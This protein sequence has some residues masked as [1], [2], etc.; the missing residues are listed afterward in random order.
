MNQ[1]NI[2]NGTQ[3][4]CK[5]CGAMFEIT[6]CHST[7]R[8]PY[9]DA[10]YAT[11]TPETESDAV[12][13]ERIRAQAA[14]DLENARRK[15]EAEAKKAAKNEATIEKF[16]KGLWSKLLVLCIAVCGFMTY[17]SFSGKF[18]PH[19][20]IFLAQTLLLLLAWLMGMGVFK[21][22][23]RP[24]RI[25]ITLMAV[26]LIFPY[27]ELPSKSE[28]SRKYLRDKIVWNNI[29]MHEIIPEPDKLAGDVTR[30]TSKELKLSLVN[31]ST[32]EYSAYRQAC[33]DA[34]FTIDSSEKSY[35]NAYAAYNE[36]GYY[37]D[38]DYWSSSE[39][40]RI[41]LNAPMETEQLDWT[42][43]VLGN[44]LPAPDSS[45]GNIEQNS[46]SS[47]SAYISNVTEED[48][49]TYT[50]RCKDAGFTLDAEESNTSFFAMNAA[51]Y[52]L[53]TS[54]EGFNR[55]HIS[56]T[57]P[58]PQIDFP[59]SGPGAKLPKPSSALG[60]IESDSSKSFSV[61]LCGITADDFKNYVNQCEAAGFTVD[62]TKSAQEFSAGSA[63]GYKL[64]ISYDSSK[65]MEISITAPKTSTATQPITQAATA[66]ATT[67][68]TEATQPL[69]TQTTSTAQT[70][71]ALTNG[72]RP[73]FKKAMDSYE[74]FIDEYCAFMTK[75]DSNE[76]SALTMAID[77]AK[78]IAKYAEMARDF[79]AWEDD[80]LNDT[81]FSY[82][83]Q[84]QSRVL[85]KL[86]AVAQ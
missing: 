62:Y 78:Y 60:K 9:C 61:R 47:F 15:N 12:K 29:E 49:I 36:A 30:N 22:P 27:S 55:M 16:K 86:A 37:I 3:V 48:F 75:Y 4:T 39:E 76:G 35:S 44:I 14:V 84:V 5:H 71:S 43:V 54:R 13:I 21:K 25:F 31:Y 38:L 80:D 56:V 2:S 52:L 24:L 85:Q 69:P 63:D 8:C 68:V 18:Y 1:P 33:I 10:V 59:T 40:I 23:Y 66:P 26:A 53:K 81:E 46:G 42:S 32:Q 6:D 41:H 67:P 72:M 45:E 73:E 7:I 64:T 17:S 83:L 79:D 58:D 74:A 51:R 34:G 11:P 77:Y 57:A 70:G 28:Y 50:N 20:A 19:G 82:Y 65:H